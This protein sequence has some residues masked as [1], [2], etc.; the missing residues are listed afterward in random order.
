VTLRGG[1]EV[2]LAA[3]ELLAA[4]GALDVHDPCGCVAVSANA[5]ERIGRPGVDVWLT[6]TLNGPIDR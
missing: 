2:D 3:R 1:G 4:G 6:V 5:S